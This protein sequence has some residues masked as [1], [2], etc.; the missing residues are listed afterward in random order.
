[1]KI[2]NLILLT[3][4]FSSYFCTAHEHRDLLQKET[5]LSTLKKSLVMN[6]KWVPYPDY[7]DRAG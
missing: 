2:F 4:L 3:I 5:D 1:M 7:N 6:Q